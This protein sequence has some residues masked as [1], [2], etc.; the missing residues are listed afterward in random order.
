MGVLRI[1][2]IQAGMEL[3]QDIVSFNGSTLLK[4]GAVLTEKHLN[5]FQMW[6]I[7]EADIKG[8]DDDNAEEMNQNDIH[9]EIFQNIVSELDRLFQKSDLEDP[10]T[11][12]LYR[13]RKNFKLKALLHGKA[14]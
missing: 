4:S 7:T 13:I 6:G 12:E 2:Q 10:I 1:E 14:E 8:I 3:A 5:A 9:P 11:A